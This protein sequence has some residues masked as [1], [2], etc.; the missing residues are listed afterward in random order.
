[1]EA[2]SG[3]TLNLNLALNRDKSSPLSKAPMTPS[4]IPRWTVAS[5]LP[6]LPGTEPRTQEPWNH[7]QLCPRELTMQVRAR[8]PI[9]PTQP[10]SAGI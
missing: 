1:M 5:F 6:T 4:G 3:Q 10:H 2:K 7:C 9:S 8:L